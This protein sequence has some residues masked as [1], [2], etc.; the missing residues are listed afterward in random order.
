VGAVAALVS[1]S[2][3]DSSLPQVLVDDTRLALGHLAAAWRRQCPAQVVAITGSN[4]K[5]TVKEMTAAILS[6]EGP[7]LATRGNFNNDIGLPL[8]LLRLTPK[9]R[10]AVVEMGAN[11][12][13]EIA[14]L[15]AIGRPDVAVVNNAGPA[16]LE[17]FGDIAGV[18][19]AKGEIFAG[20]RDDGIAIVNGDD[21]YAETWCD[22]AGHRR[23]LRFGIGTQGTVPADIRATDIDGSAFTLHTPS[24][25]A[26][27]ELPLPGR[28]NISNALAAA[29]AAHALGLGIEA[30]V[31]GLQRVE[32]VTGRLN[33]TVLGNGATLIDDTYNANPASVDAALAVLVERPGRH[34]LVL[35]DLAELGPDT[36]SIHRE[37]GAK[38]RQLGIDALY[39]SGPASRLSS[40]AF[41][42]GGQHFD[43]AE[44][45]ATALWAKL[46]TNTSVLVKGSRSAAMERVANELT[47]KR[48]ERP[49]SPKK[50]APSFSSQGVEG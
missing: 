21:R 1:V 18:A 14:A 6:A 43:S 24:G 11:H 16:H 44:D 39:S 26:R 47:K 32:P 15:S 20:L 28:H 12:P 23:H 2:S 34:I 4:G 3:D 9:H 19:R 5:T 30:I 7:T 27:V 10:Y 29:A 25:D 48:T 37:I 38:A 42:T 22:L 13:C 49:F 35:G 17:G 31:A 8:T 50:D 33:V 45:L 36:D 46:D 41:G 40:E